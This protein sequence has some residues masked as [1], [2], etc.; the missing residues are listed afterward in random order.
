VRRPYF[1]TIVAGVVLGTS[2]AAIGVGVAP[3]APGMGW[4]RVDPAHTRLLG[5]LLISHANRDRRN[6][7]EAGSN[8]PLLAIRQP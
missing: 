3:V 2:I 1:A 4:C 6:R 7:A 5:L 8:P